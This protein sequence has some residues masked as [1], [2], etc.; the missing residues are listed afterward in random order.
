MYLHARWASSKY[1]HDNLCVSSS[2]LKIIL[3]DTDGARQQPF[4]TPALTNV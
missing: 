4:T 3:I 2:E 1:L